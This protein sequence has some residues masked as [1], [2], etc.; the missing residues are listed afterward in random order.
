MTTYIVR[1]LLVLPVIVLGVTM[2]IFALLS[3]LTP[4]ERASLYVADVPKR[5]GSIEGVIEKYGLDDPV[6]TQYW[7]WMVG[8]R[9]PDTEEVRGGIL[10]GQLGFS[11]TLGA[12]VIDVL[13]RRLPATAELAVWA[14]VPMIGMGILLG[15]LSA[16]HHNRFIDQV[17]RV[18]SIVGWSIPTFVFGLI[19]LM[20]FYARL[21]WFPPGRLSDWAS[22]IV[23]SDSFRQF[24]RMHT[25]DALLNLRFDIFLDAVKHL[26]LPIT[27]L[28]YLNWAYLLRVTR[29]SM[30][31][32]LRQEYLTTARSKGLIERLVIM[33]H[34]L[35]NALIPIITV[36]GLILVGLLNGVVITETIFNYPGMG[37]FLAH[38]ALSL[39]AISVLGVT[40]FSSLILVAG[41]LVVDVLYGFADPRIRLE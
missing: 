13:R 5:Q 39:D 33:R 10:R 7:H 4:Y 34:A 35:P 9:D 6:Y 12:S 2:L 15:V 25:L 40:L 32:V 23:Q 41:N 29:S 16:V 37:S 21:G 28:A 20:I 27:T 1:R 14:A 17:L 19:V 36:G 3:L 11:K 24:T 30:L 26:V 31:D 8:R 38:A 18:F 22:Q